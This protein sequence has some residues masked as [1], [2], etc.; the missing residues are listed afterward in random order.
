MFFFNFYS[1]PV[2]AI[3]KLMS[4][5]VYYS[6]KIEILQI[7]KSHYDRTLIIN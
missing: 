7:I 3:V 5:F 2:L 4:I 1:Y 6:L